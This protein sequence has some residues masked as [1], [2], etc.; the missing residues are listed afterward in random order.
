MQA[1]FKRHRMCA[2]GFVAGKPLITLFHFPLD[3]LLPRPE[4]F[5][6]KTATT[7]DVQTRRRG[8]GIHVRDPHHRLTIPYSSTPCFHHL[9]RLADTF[10]PDDGIAPFVETGVADAAMIA[11]CG[12]FG[13]HD[14][15]AEVFDD[16]VV[17]DGFDP[18]GAAGGDLVD[19]G[20][21]GVAH[22]TA[23]RGGDQE[24]VAVPGEGGIE[25]TVRP[26]WVED[27]KVIC[28]LLA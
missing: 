21:G 25:F 12:A 10:L 27:A 26:D 22:V 17:F 3:L 6:P 8:I 1:L 15:G 23:P 14:V 19:H 18:V 13:G 2:H 7:D 4:Q 16:A 9:A 24:Y 20:R 5:N 11:P 28:P